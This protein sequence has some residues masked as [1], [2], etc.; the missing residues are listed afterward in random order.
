MKKLSLLF[1]G[2]I[3]GA[4]L[5]AQGPKVMIIPFDPD[6]YFCDSD[7][8]LAEF[9]KLNVKEVRHQ[10][11]YGLNMNLNARVLSAYGTKTM[12]TDTTS[13]VAK[14]LYAIYK[15]ISYYADKSM[16]SSSVTGE[17]PKPSGKGTGGVFNKN[18]N[19]KG[20]GKGTGTKSSNQIEARNYMNVKIHNPAML[21]YL[22]DKYGTEVFLFINQFNLATNY[23]HCLDR[24]NNIFEREVMI[25]FSIFDYTGKQLAGD[26]AIVNL[27]SNNN[28]LDLIIK[29]KFPVISDYI[30]GQLPHNSTIGN[31][32]V[33]PSHSIKQQ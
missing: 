23:A 27:P 16:A 4:V 32:A 11:R 14:D 10:F 17:D 15:G 29:E 9:N 18:T 8:Q 7:Q 5:M 6:M 2:L 31:D 21:Q 33:A 1:V 30:K 12:L 13:D 20:Q 28:N 25:H 22:H 26:V 19:T 24:A 3:W